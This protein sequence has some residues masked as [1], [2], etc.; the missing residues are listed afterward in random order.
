MKYFEDLKWSLT[1][2]SGKLAICGQ[3]LFSQFRRVNHLHAGIPG[4]T[5]PD[6]LE[7]PLFAAA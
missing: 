4:A 5:A 3:I 2:K 6:A 7:R 1:Q